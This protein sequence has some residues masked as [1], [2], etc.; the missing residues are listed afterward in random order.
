MKNKNWK[1]NKVVKKIIELR[2][3]YEFKHLYAGATTGFGEAKVEDLWECDCCG[4]L[5]NSLES[6][7]HKTDVTKSIGICTNCSRLWKIFIPK[8]I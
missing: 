7:Y 3:N 6:V 1:D 2:K 8:R 5:S 4:T